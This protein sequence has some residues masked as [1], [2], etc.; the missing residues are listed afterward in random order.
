MLDIETE[1][2]NNPVSA[3]ALKVVKRLTKEGHEA[4]LV[5]GCVRDLLL[6]KSPKD[7]DVATSAHPDE[8]LGIFRNARPIG[9]RFKIVHIRFGREIIEVATFRAPRNSAETQ[10][11]FSETGMILSDNIYGTFEEDVFRRDF[12][13]NALYYDANSNAIKDLVGGLDDIKNQQIQLIGNPEERYRED[14]V[15]MLRA[16]RFK[17]KLGFDLEPQTA[18]LLRQ[19]G[20]LLHAIPAARL[21]DEVLKLFMSGHGEQSLTTLNEYDLFGWLFPATHHSLQGKSNIETNAQID[22]PD[23]QSSEINSSEIK[24]SE[25]EYSAKLIQLALVSTDTRIRNAKPVTPAFVYAALLWQPYIKEK[26][27]LEQLDGH[28]E[29]SASHQAAT[30]VITKQQSHTAIPRRFSVTIR[31][32]WHLQSRLPVRFGKKAEILLAHKRFRAAYDFFVLREAS[33]EQLDGVG[34]WWTSYQECNPDERL[35]MTREIAKPKR[36]RKRKRRPK[37]QS[38]GE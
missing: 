30:H 37:R 5:G 6:G 19:F 16:L 20:H 17:A 25:T 35:K 14:P 36:K 18:Q 32:I 24:S 3:N 7:F 33:G 11:N 12:T 29:T 2:S 1:L 23:I 21:F 8:V 22:S 4:Y 10:A 34:Q 27:R 38:P 26:R 28:T 15:R 31:E 9:R 13:M